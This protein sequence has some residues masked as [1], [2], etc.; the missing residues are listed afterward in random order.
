MQDL[1]DT[2]FTSKFTGLRTLLLQLRG[3]ELSQ[4][5][6]TILIM[7]GGTCIGKSIA[8]HFILAPVATVN[9]VEHRWTSLDIASIFS[10]QPL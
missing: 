5:G 10:K 2:E 9:I 6:R 3:L 1:I 7:G 4:A 8:Q